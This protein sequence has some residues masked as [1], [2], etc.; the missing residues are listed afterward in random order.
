MNKFISVLFILF[1]NNAYCQTYFHPYGT[2]NISN[3]QNRGEMQVQPSYYNFNYLNGFQIDLN[4]AF[5]NLLFLS[6]SI[7]YAKGDD[8]SDSQINTLY[9]DYALI[10]YKQFSVD[11]KIGIYQHTTLY[12]FE[13]NKNIYYNFSLGIRYGNLSAIDNRYNLLNFRKEIIALPILLT[14][15]TSNDFSDLYMFYEYSKNFQT[16]LNN[17][18]SDKLERLNNEITNHYGPNNSYNIHQFGLGINLGYKYLKFNTT[19]SWVN[20]ASLKVG[21]FPF[22]IN[23]GPPQFLAGLRITLF[24]SDNI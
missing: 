22:D 1:L 18:V 7:N 19:V 12:E 10:Y 8:N 13:Q 23:P 2:A 24:T 14:V 21:N 6:S 17:F 20:K 4:Y 9:L 15:G 5:T 3:L 11:S 16:K